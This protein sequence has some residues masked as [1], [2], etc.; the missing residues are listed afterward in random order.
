MAWNMDDRVVVTM[1]RYA[2]DWPHIAVCL[3]GP[4]N[5]S[6]HAK[7]VDSNDL[8]AVFEV[9]N[10]SKLPLLCLVGPQRDWGPQANCRD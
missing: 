9:G 7:A 4:T 6:P 3:A 5:L 1:F 10:E 2:S 8:L